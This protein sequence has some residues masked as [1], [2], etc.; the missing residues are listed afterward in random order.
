MLSREQEE[1][2]RLKILR[3]AKY[4]I[5]HGGKIDEVS[6]ATGIPFSSIQRYL[7]D[8][9]IINELGKDVYDAIQEKVKQNKQE[10]LSKGGRTYA[11]NN[12]YTKNEAGKFTGSRKK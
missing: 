1:Q 12:K 9:L 5:E 6:I 3:V 4:F 10:G 11:S 8:P 7:H 2:K